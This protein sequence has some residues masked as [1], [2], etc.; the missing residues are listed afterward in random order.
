M[1]DVALSEAKTKWS[2]VL[3]EMFYLVAD[4]FPRQISGFELELHNF[5]FRQGASGL[6]CM[7]T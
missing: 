2:M 4:D 7:R 3:C 6:D 5:E 1:W